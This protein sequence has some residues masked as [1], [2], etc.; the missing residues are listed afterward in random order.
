MPYVGN[1]SRE[2][3]VFILFVIIYVRIYCSSDAFLSPSALFSAPFLRGGEGR[4]RVE[5]ACLRLEVLLF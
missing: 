3:P 2:G 4:L 1:D 5:G